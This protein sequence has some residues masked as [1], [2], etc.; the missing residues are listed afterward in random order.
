MSVLTSWIFPPDVELIAR[1]TEL[2]V[3]FPAVIAT[4]DPTVLYVKAEN[5]LFWL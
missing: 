3:W 5:W 2:E 4:P 1:S